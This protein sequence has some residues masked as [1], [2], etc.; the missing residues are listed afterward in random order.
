MQKLEFELNED[1]IEL[2]KLLKVVG[3]SDSGGAA[4]A[5]VAGGEIKVDGAV[6]LRKACKIRIG[7]VVE[8]EGFQI[9]VRRPVV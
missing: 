5:L 8:A 9:T 1:F 4:K 2:H 6:E 3:A 7:Q